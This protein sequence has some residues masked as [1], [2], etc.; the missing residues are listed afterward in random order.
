MGLADSNQR[1]DSL[2]LPKYLLHRL[3]SH[4]LYRHYFHLMQ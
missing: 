3:M 1:Q 4:L 2:L